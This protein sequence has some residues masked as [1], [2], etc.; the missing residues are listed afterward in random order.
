W[1]FFHKLRHELSHSKLR[2][3]CVQNFLSYVRMR[4]WVD[5]HLQLLELIK[6]A[7]L[8]VGPRT[9]STPAAE[10]SRGAEEHTYAAVHRAILTGMPVVPKRR[11][12]YGEIDP[13]RSRELFIQHA[14]VEGDFE[15][16]PLGRTGEFLPHNLALVKELRELE[17]KARRRDLL[18]GEEAIFDF[19]AQRL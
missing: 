17:I 7:G 8:H 13:A 1:D 16:R 12:R 15:T 3:A 6:E 11:V 5:L 14:L 9:T 2:K 19:Y 4:E 10:S 18:R